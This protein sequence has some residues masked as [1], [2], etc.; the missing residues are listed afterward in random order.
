MIRLLSG[1]SLLALFSLALTACD[2]METV[3]SPSI[4]PSSTAPS[5]ETPASAKSERVP[6][7]AVNAQRLQPADDEPG[8]WMSYGRTSSVQRFS[9]LAQINADNA[10][11]LELA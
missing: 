8:T 4:P 7:A 1:L 6:A 11:A 10:A 2:R 5:I 3:T 9:P